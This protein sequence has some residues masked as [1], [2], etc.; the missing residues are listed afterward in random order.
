MRKIG[1]NQSRMADGGWG[2]RKT[3]RN[4]GRERRG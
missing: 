4:Q 2:M 1:I 3:G